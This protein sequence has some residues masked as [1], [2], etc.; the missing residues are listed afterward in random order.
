MLENEC[1]KVS[2]VTLVAYMEKKK[3]DLRKLKRSHYRKQKQEE[4]KV[5]NGLFQADPGSVYS[6]FNEM[7]KEEKDNTRP[8]YKTP[9]CTT[10]G[11]ERQMFENIDEASSYWK[12]LWE[13]SSTNISTTRVSWLNEVKR[14]FDKLVLVPPADL[15]Q[16]STEAS[17]KVIK[18]KRNW[19]APGPDRLAN[20]WWK[21][22]TCLHQGIA[23]CF[24]AI[25]NG[26]ENYPHWFTGGKT[27]LIPKPGEFIS[28]NQRPI[29]CLNT[30]YKWFTSCLLKPINQNLDR[31][32]LMETEQRGVKSKCSGTTDNLLID[33]MVCQ[34]SHNAHKNLSMA[35][36]DV[37]KAF[38]SVS[39]E[40]LQEI[41]SLH[42]FAGWICRTVERLCRSWNT[43][44]VAHTKQGHETSQVIHFNKG[45]PQGDAL[46]SR[47]F[48]MCIN[49]I[50]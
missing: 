27:T 38:D 14:G 42:K 6:S 18:Q 45:L 46:C 32:R 31:H 26:E 22:A 3:S 23:T 16:L 48:T 50:A 9:Q 43:R 1:G 7:I 4:S 28:E 24:A 8:K 39:H 29:T 12:S 13:Q 37:R 2:A 30:L 35:W 11:S 17:T 25:G 40:W 19:S 5:L 34:D 21:K 15:F 44:I 47:L 36:I 33:R 49:P 41:M 10:E 20:F